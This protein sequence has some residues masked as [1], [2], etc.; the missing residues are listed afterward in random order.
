M[1]SSPPIG[2]PLL[3]HAR[4]TARALAVVVGLML[5]P[6]YVGL[7]SASVAGASTTSSVFYLD[8]GGSGSVGVQPTATNPHGEPTA[9]G[10]ANDLVTLEAAQGIA[11]QLVQ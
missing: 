7:G 9:F 11:L 2:E 10:Y 3:F 4:R 6:L 8:I 1:A 5:A